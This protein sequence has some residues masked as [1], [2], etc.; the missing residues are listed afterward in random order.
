V[1]K[2]GDK[3]NVVE[4]QAEN[5]LNRFKEFIEDA[6]Y[7]SGAWR[8]TVGE[9]SA[10]GSPGVDDAAAS[11]GDSG[12]AGVSGK[13]IAGVGV[14]AAAAVGVAAAS[15]RKDD[16][17]AAPAEPA[18]TPPVTP[19]SAPPTTVPPTGTTGSVFPGE[20]LDQGRGPGA[21]GTVPADSSADRPD[22]A[23]FD[24]T[25]GLVDTEGDSDGTAASDTASA[26]EREAGTKR[27]SDTLPP[28]GGSLGQH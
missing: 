19:R 6:G 2:V 3:L 9:G 12:K 16:T 26:A 15:G 7:A 4:K 13:L 27:V 18:Q 5:D 10:A 25:N 20:G 22:A 8:G 24:Q 11:R 17:E 28:A 1:E 23:P 21:S 14:A